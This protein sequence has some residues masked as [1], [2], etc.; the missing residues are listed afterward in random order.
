MA[1]SGDI[2]NFF[3][4]NRAAPNDENAAENSRS[5]RR[6]NNDVDDPEPVNHINNKGQS[7]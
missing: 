6:R 5:I 7:N 4:K 2:Q 1:G 3:L